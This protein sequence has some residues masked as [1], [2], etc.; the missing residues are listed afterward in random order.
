MMFKK[1][2]V[3]LMVL[4]ASTF[5]FAGCSDDSD[6]ECVDTPTTGCDSVQTCCS[7]D[8]CYYEADGEKF[9]CDGL[10]CTAAAT[11]LVDHCM[12]TTEE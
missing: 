8:D 7:T 10:D 6:Y 3:V 1:F 2:L 12:G 5:Y 9:E 4:A 11:A